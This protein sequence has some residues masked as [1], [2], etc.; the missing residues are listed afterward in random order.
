MVYL[1]FC[2][3]ESLI[4]NGRGSSNEHWGYRMRDALLTREDSN[5]I[6]TD[7]SGGAFESY[8][9]STG[10]ARLVGAQIA[11]LIKFII[12]RNGDS[13]DLANRFYLIGFSLG[14][15]ITGYAGSRL[16]QER[17]KLSRITGKI[18]KGVSLDRQLVASVVI[19]PH[20]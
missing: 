6:L 14:A 18:R 7:W 5:V 1:I 19:K 8:G 4:D 3:P 17:M 11:E 15:Q 10:N 2:L 16:R 13:K 9:Q 20:M 12:K